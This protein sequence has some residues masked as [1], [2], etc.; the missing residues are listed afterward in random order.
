M[1]IWSFVQAAGGPP[2]F[3]LED[4][5]DAVVLGLVEPDPPPEVESSDP[6]PASTAVAL[7]IATTAVIDFEIITGLLA[8]W[9]PR[10]PYS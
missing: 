3:A 9:V 10:K 6:Q 7:A 2:T 8:L 1:L 5:D 4:V